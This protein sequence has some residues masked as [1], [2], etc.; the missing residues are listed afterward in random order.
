[1]IFIK[2]VE[3]FGACYNAVANYRFW[4][5][6]VS[7]LIWCCGSTCMRSETLFEV[8]VI[9]HICEFILCVSLFPFLWT[10]IILHNLTKHVLYTRSILS[11]FLLV[12]D[13][14]MVITPC[15]VSLWNVIH[16]ILF[17][18][19][20]SIDYWL[21][22]DLI[23]PESERFLKNVVR[24]HR[25]EE[26]DLFYIPFFTTISFFLLEKQQ[27]KALYRVWVTF[28]AYFKCSHSWRLLCSLCFLYQ[29]YWISSSSLRNMF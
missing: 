29:N 3:H 5:F 26:A 18:M 27:C 20:H 9:E 19:Q 8:I 12:C 23:A 16:F 24:V 4:K 2:Y 21:W 11:A 15:F 17:F 25:Q 28:E 10:E 14:T 7:R 13:L 1:M 6:Y 22:A